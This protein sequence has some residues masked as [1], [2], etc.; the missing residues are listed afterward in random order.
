MAYNLY[1][2]ACEDI[3]IGRYEDAQEKLEKLLHLNKNDYKVLNKLGVI[4]AYK[5]DKEKALDYF[6]SSLYANSE[7]APAYVNIAN[8]YQEEGNIELAEQFYLKAIEVDPDYALAYYNL[9]VLYKKK[10][11]IE[12]WVKNFKQYK[13]LLKREE[14]NYTNIKEMNV[15]KKKFLIIGPILT[16][17]VIYVL[18]VFLFK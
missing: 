7:Y 10:G 4:Y 14:Y 9:G 2:S 3:E 5:G 18:L 13:R 1:I 12:L 6:N 16:F 11:Q 17:L 15:N 8:L